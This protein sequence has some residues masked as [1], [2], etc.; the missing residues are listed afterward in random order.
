MDILPEIIDSM[1]KEE[2]RFFKLIAHRQQGNEERRDLYLLDE[3]R[4]NRE[5]AE[6]KTLKRFYSDGDKNAFYRLK[7]RLIDDINRS[8]VLQHAD[9]E[10]L[11]AVYKLMQI[12][13]I[14]N[15]KNK[16]ALAFHFLK[17][18]ELKAQKNEF[19]EILDIIYGEFIRLSNE[20]LVIDPETYVNLR[21]ENTRNLSRIRQLDDLL[22]IVSHRLKLTQNMGQRHQ[23]LL[24]I[25]EETISRFSDDKELA[26]S[27]RFRF[28][29]Y[30]L[31]SQTLLQKQDYLTLEEYLRKTFSEFSGEQLFNRGNHE[32]KLQ[33]LTYLVNSLFKNGK[34]EESLQFAEQLHQ[35]M[36]AF[37]NLLYERFEVFYYNALVNNYSTFDIPRAIEIL[38]NL[39][40]NPNLQKVP[41]YEL[42]VYLNLATSYFD[43]KQ[44]QQAARQ[45]G[46]AAICASFKKADESVKFKM[47]IA[48][49][50]IR[51]ELGDFDFWLYRKEQIAKTFAEALEQDRFRKES[52]LIQLMF[53]VVSNPDG[54]RSR[55][56]KPDVLQF[57]KTWTAVPEDGEIIRYTGWI[58]EKIKS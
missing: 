19:H 41:F 21:K 24:G 45:L 20:L 32:T 11:L 13:R 49:L 34:V 38:Q 23:D 14:Y 35:A 50:I 58:K 22:A 25:L 4:K 39:L 40:K 51:F 53:K 28:K 30:G 57:V 44:F 55:T 47:A 33:M 37:N 16:F 1:N 43:L 9:E 6:G 5:N 29:V 31:V 56:L 54:F 48:E 46:K 17:K 26:A 8:L 15:S 10:E 2:L 36:Q 12:V 18:A 7:N 42:F 3:L 52:E 27:P